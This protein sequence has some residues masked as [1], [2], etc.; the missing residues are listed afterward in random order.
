MAEFSL[1]ALQQDSFSTYYGEQIDRSDD[2]VETV[3]YP[4]NKLTASTKSRH[5]KK[6]ISPKNVF[7]T[8]IEYKDGRPTEFAHKLYGND[9]QWAT[10]PKRLYSVCFPKIHLGS[11]PTNNRIT[12]QLTDSIHQELPYVPDEF[13]K[14][15]QQKAHRPTKPVTRRNKRQRVSLTTTN[16]SEN[17]S[18]WGVYGVE[19]PSENT[20]S[21]EI[22]FNQL[23]CI[24]D[25]LDKKDTVVKNPF[26]DM[27]SILSNEEKLST[28]TSVVQFV[29][30]YARPELR[31]QHMGNEIL[32]DGVWDNIKD[33]L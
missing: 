25:E 6:H 24:M 28:F 18:G 2:G 31:M 9:H 22:L 13:Y 23:R 29:Y 11:I 10:L 32:Q 7:I 1:P 21:K 17:Y 27:E 15:K 33:N 20:L 4:G 5:L 3:V 12:L 8:K 26:T 14:Q 30:H 16:E 19:T